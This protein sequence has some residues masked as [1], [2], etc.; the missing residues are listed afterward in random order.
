MSRKMLRLTSSL[1][2]I[3]LTAILITVPYAAAQTSTWSKT[4]GGVNTDRAYGVIKTQEGGYALLGTTNSFGAGLIN[5]LL[6]KTDVDGNILWNQTYSGIGQAIADA[7]VQASDHGYAM[8]GYSYSIADESGALSA[9]AIKVDFS[10]AI[11]WNQTYPQLGTAI[12]YAIIQTSD[13]GFAFVGVTNSIGNG[14]KESWLAKVDSTGNLQWNKTYGD[15]GDDEFFT[16]M[17]TTDGGYT[18]GGDTSPTQ[19]GPTQLWLVK[20]DAEGNMLWNQTYNVGENNYMSTLVKTSDGGYALTGTAQNSAGDDYLLIKTDSAGVLQW[21]KTY[22]ASPLD[23][24]LSGIQTSDGGYALVGVSNSSG[25]PFVKS[26]MVKT[27]TAGNMQWNQTYG[28]DGVDVTGVVLQVADGYVLGGYTNATGA[29]KEDFWLY[30]VDANGAG[31][32]VASPSPSQSPTPSPTVPELPGIA[33]V[34]LLAALI[35]PAVILKRKIT[36]RST[37]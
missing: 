23:D 29:G 12:G 33:A 34:S 16:I 7:I 28:G 18:L 1:I 36:K 6:V 5:A 3:T 2:F 26:W 17:Q 13:G 32:T 11:E 21:S 30:K 25:A 14:G 37:Q 10:G 35:V 22:S 9:W 8:T 20:T 27:D 31:T 4:Y 19:G 24:A 15:V